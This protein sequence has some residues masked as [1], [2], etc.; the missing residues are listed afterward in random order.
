MTELSDGVNTDQL[1]PSLALLMVVYCD[2]HRKVF[3]CELWSVRKVLRGGRDEKVVRDF[4]K[5]LEFLDSHGM[6]VGTGLRNYEGYLDF[7]L[8]SFESRCIIPG[9]QSLKSIPL[10]KRYLLTPAYKESQLGPLPDYR[11]V[12]RYDMRGPEFLRLLGLDDGSN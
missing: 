9:P 5:L 12:L 10:L 3:G 6:Q 11:K 4:T 2:I 1:P 8:R 7:S